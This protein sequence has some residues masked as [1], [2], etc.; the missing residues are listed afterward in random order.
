MPECEVPSQ[1]LRLQ[2]WFAGAIT[3]PLSEAEAWERRAREARA[4]VAPHVRLAPARRVGI[5]REQYWWRLIGTLQH[6]FPTLVR[7]FGYDGFND[8][9]ALPFLTAY[10][11]RE[12]SITLLGRELPAWIDAHYAAQD[13]PLVRCA[14]MV[15]LAFLELAIAPLPQTLSPSPRLLSQNL[16]LQAHVR[17]FSFP[18]DLFPFR[19]KLLQESVEYWLDAP[20]PPLQRKGPYFY[21]LVRTARNRMLSQKLSVGEWALVQAIAAGQTIEEACKAQEAKG[22]RALR[23]ATSHLHEWI[24]AWMRNQW[25]RR[26][27]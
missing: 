2:K 10:P 5:Y 19:K 1:L 17:L 14:A 15:D 3:I 25:F 9:L 23:E 13:K 24:A 4:Y 27:E 26:V 21:A 12:W 8:S 11:P 16:E 18:F 20:F 7:L 22:G 6:N